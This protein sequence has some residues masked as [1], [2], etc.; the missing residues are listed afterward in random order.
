MEGQQQYQQQVPYQSPVSPFSG[1]IVLLTNPES[2]LH[3]MEL[4]LRNI[5]QDGDGNYQKVGL[6]LMNE[7]GIR[8][9]IG[10][11]HYIVNQIT[12]FSEL[13]PAIINNFALTLADDLTLTLML[14]K[15]KYAIR[16]HEFTRTIIV[17][18]I[19]MASYICMMRAH[20][21]GERKF[22]KGSTQEI[23]SRV[24]GMPKKGGIMAKA[25]GWSK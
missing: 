13:K 1:S 18:G 14:S 8:F 10:T 11:A 3:T 20:E 24:E 2:E 23:T 12:V 21:G 22:W 19:S 16:N 15:R 7:E 17:D 6:P 4:K 5:I 9:I 25:L